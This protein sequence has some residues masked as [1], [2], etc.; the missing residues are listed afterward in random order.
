MRKDRYEL[1][2]KR[3]KEEGHTSEWEFLY[4]AA[5]REE[6]DAYYDRNAKYWYNGE[7]VYIFRVSFHAETV[8]K[9]KVELT[10]EEL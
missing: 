3:K 8:V 7:T 1:C 5:T 10:T 2:R 9:A 4:G 6:V